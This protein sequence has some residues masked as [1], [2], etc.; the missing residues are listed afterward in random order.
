MYV[1][2]RGI[3]YNSVPTIFLLNFGF[4]L[5]VWYFVGLVFALLYLFLNV[6][7]RVDT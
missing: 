4:V 1:C 3:N 6:S 7:F 5:T 2:V